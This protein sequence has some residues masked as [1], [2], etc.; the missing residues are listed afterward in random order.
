MELW[1]EEIECFSENSLNNSHMYFIYYIQAYVS[2]N[3]KGSEL[4]DVFLKLKDSLIKNGEVLDDL[5]EEIHCRI[6]EL[7]AQ[8]STY[9]ILASRCGRQPGD[10]MDRS[11]E[12]KAG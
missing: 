10:P 9:T 6:E 8:V 1:G 11:R 4:Q 7:D 3:R 5:K 12:R 2:V